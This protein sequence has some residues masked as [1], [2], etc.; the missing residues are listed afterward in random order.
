MTTE[1]LPTYEQ[2][3][4]LCFPPPD[5]STVA[6]VST[7]SPFHHLYTSP[8]LNVHPVIINSN[9]DLTNVSFNSYHSMTEA[10]I[11]NLYTAVVIALDDKIKQIE[12][13][14]S[15]IEKRLRTRTPNHY[16]RRMR[17]STISDFKKIESK[18]QRDLKCLD[19]I[20]NELIFQNSCFIEADASV[21]IIQVK[22]DQSTTKQ[23]K[24]KYI[25]QL[26]DNMKIRGE[27]VCNIEKIQTH[28]GIIT[29]DDDVSYVLKERAKVYNDAKELVRR[30]SRV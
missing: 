12:L 3:V 20:F 24:S 26:M 9:D 7:Q 18:I 28:L 17:D 22:L 30:Q 15:F 1:Q 5:Y 6:A 11:N 25:N 29:S 8:S 4:T 2:S 16:V 27:V 14:T 23:E 21:A 10:E 19:S 13:N